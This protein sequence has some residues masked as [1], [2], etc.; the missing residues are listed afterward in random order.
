MSLDSFQLHQLL[1][2]LDIDNMLKHRFKVL[3]YIFSISRDVVGVVVGS[4]IHTHLY[5]FWICFCLFVGFF[6]FEM[7]YS[8]LALATSVTKGDVVV[9]RKLP[10][11]DEAVWLGKVSQVLTSGPV[12]LEW[13]TEGEGGKWLVD[14]NW[15]KDKIQRKNILAT[16]KH[17]TGEGLMPNGLME[18]LLQLYQE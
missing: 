14:K 1:S 6:D 15:Q 10:E 17:W 7:R 8:H 4:N 12:K 3:A 9:V 18:Q 13:I 11:S 16:V 5:L 2:C